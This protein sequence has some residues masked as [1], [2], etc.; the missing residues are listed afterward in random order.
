MKSNTPRNTKSI[1]K[2]EGIQTW[3]HRRFNDKWWDEIVKFAQ[4]GC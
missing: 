4:E 3:E 1:W 2:A